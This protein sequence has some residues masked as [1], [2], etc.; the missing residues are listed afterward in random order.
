MIVIE[1]RLHTLQLAAQQAQCI[2]TMY[3]SGEFRENHLRFVTLV[4]KRFNSDMD[5]LVTKRFNFYMVR[6]VTKRFNSI[7]MILQE[8]RKHGFHQYQFSL[9]ICLLSTS[10]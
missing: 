2:E 6:S 8:K 3:H 9:C 1:V 10:Q 7:F 4:T 5:A